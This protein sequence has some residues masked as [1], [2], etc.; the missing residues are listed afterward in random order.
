MNSVIK[1]PVYIGK[2]IDLTDSLYE[3]SWIS[4]LKEVYIDSNLKVDSD[5]DGNP[6]NDKDSISKANIEVQ[7][8]STS[9]K[10]KILPFDSIF[11]KN[12]R[13]YMVDKNNNIWY[14]DLVLTVYSPTPEIKW[15]NNSTIFGDLNE[16]IDKER[17]DLYRYRWGVLKR[18]TKDYVNTSA[19]WAFQYN[20][21]N[22]QGL[23]LKDISNTW[24]IKDIAN[25]NETTWK[26]DL[27]DNKY[28]IRIIPA[29]SSDNAYTNIVVSNWS[30]DL[31][32]EYIVVPN[33]WEVKSVDSFDNI[34]DNWTYFRLTDKRN[35]SSFTIPTTTSY[36]PW[37]L[38]VYDVADNNKTPI[39]VVTKDW[40]V[41]VNR[42]WFKIVYDNFW[43]RIVYKL[44]DSSGK[45]IARVL[46]I[47]EWNFIMK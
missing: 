25:I 27:K 36:N 28:S 5:W 7:L 34:K 30:L 10:L 15:N 42:T 35:Y 47:R 32:Y 19:T 41:S 13:L 14:K 18:L 39:F 3:N 17:V 12:I 23:V 37:D 16:N 43:D 9:L 11:T 6:A 21:T 20:Y 29:N 33:I 45:E 38:A 4:G 46:P 26:I 31:Y 22:S 44:I 8:S 40:R 1:V 24:A 2:T